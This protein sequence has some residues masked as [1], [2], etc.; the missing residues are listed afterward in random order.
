[1]HLFL[2]G[3]LALSGCNSGSSSIVIPTIPLTEQQNIAIL[4]EDAEACNCN[5]AIDAVAPTEKSH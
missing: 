3:L 1:M 2:L 4:R 5:S